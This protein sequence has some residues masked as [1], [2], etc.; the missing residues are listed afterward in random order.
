MQHILA[1]IGI[2]TISGLV[3]EAIFY[4]IYKRV[5]GESEMRVGLL[6]IARYQRF[7]IGTTMKK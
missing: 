2:K 7:R 1:C 4:R 6:I 5:L 3:N